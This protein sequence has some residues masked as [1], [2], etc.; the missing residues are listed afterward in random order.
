MQLIIQLRNQLI[1]RNICSKYDEMKSRQ[2]LDA[3]GGMAGW[4]C[5]ELK[6]SDWS[7]LQGMG[8]GCVF[9]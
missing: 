8:I 1:S 5:C 9:G 7:V 6:N 2:R 4:S 3:S